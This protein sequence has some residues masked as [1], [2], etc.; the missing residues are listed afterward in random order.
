MLDKIGY[1]P[2]KKDYYDIIKLL[3][4]TKPIVDLGDGNVKIRFV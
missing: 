3:D 1:N 4:Q 2:E